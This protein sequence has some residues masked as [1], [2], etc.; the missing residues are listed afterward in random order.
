[1]FS[2]S[3]FLLGSAKEVA[4]RN[5]AP[6]LY[7]E[8]E[9]CCFLYSCPLLIVALSLPSAPSHVEDEE[10]YLY[11]MDLRPSKRKAMDVGA[12]VPAVSTCLRMG[13]WCKRL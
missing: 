8:K 2:S 9:G 11:G 1:M 5:L 4:K 13:S 6:M 3:Y 12:G 7:Q 10:I